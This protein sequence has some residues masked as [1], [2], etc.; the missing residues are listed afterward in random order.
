MA[1]PNG[2]IRRGQIINVF[3]PGALMDLPHHAAIVGGLD[4]WDWG[5]DDRKR[6]I[7]EPRL[8]SKIEAA[9]ERQGLAMWEPPA[10]SQD[11]DAPPSGVV[12]YRFPEW[13]TAQYPMK[14]PA[15][16]ATGSPPQSHHPD[17][18]AR[19]RSEEIRYC[20]APLCAGVSEW[21]YL[22]HRLVHLRPWHCC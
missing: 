9:L 19:A 3:G 12:V 11:P 20:S 15:E 10:D 7:I 14:G 17:E 21:A 18:V 4:T 13:F 2:Q 8:L 22:G 6:K 5:G 1:R 16:R